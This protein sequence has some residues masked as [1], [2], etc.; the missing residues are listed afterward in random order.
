MITFLYELKL[1]NELLYYFGWINFILAL[2]LILLAGIS[3]TE[4]AGTSAWF[5]PFKFAMSIGIYSWTMAWY[6]AYLIDF[7]RTVFAWSIILLLGFEIIYITLQAARG[8]LSHFNIS[9]PLTSLLYGLMAMAAS[10]VALYTAYIGWLFWHQT[11]PELPEAYV[12]GI[13][14][15][16]LIFVVFS[17]Q[18]FMMGS[19]LSH[20]VG[21]PDGG[22]GIP[23]LNWSRTYGDLRIAHFIG[24]HALQVLPLLAYYVVRHSATI[25][26]IAILYALLAV[27]SLVRA[28]AAKPL[29]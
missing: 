15:G 13:R 19:R 27:Y 20:T 6:A 10:L 8:Q 18:G 9:T 26:F 7:N 1:R 3:K 25:V 21:A 24:M 28:M 29:W 4:V 2:V 22:G 17:F 5:K 14:L 16:I 11:F 12:W 23:I